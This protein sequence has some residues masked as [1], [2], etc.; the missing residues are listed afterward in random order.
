MA[1]VL[2]P[3]P[4]PSVVVQRRHTNRPTFTV[5]SACTL[6]LL[7]FL[8][9]IFAFA[10]SWHVRFETNLLP[11]LSITPWTLY[12]E[13]GWLT[14]IVLIITLL[15]R[16]LYL[17]KAGVSTLEYV[18]NL[19]GAVTL[20]FIIAIALTTMAL[21]F[22][23]PR[24]ATVI[25][26]GLT[27]GFVVAERL[28]VRVFL[29]GLHQRGIAQIR[30]LVI[31]S[32]ET[33]RA[34]LGRMQQTPKLGYHVVGLVDDD[35]RLWGRTLDGVAVLGAVEDL[36]RLLMRHRVDEVL[37]ADSGTNQQ[38]ILDLIARIP[39]DGID[40]KVAPSLFQLM[41]TGVSIDDLGGMPLVTVK[42]GA[43]RGWNRV[44]K[45]AMDVV[46]AA[47]VLVLFS[48][49][50]LVIAALVKLTSSGP[51]LYAQE[52]VGYNGERFQVLKY[53]SMRVDAEAGGPGWTTRDDDRRT[54]LGR[55]L[56][57][58][59]LDELPQFVNILVGDMSL[60]GPRPERP[61][62][63]EHFRRVIPRYME[64]HRERCGLTGWAQ[65]NGLRGDTSIEERTRYD[66]YYVDNWSL[67]LDL[68]IIAFT[69]L[70]VLR[71]DSAY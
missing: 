48:P 28:V 29:R 2:A 3:L 59:S 67:L 38:Q 37:I 8:A 14:A 4:E 34:M 11:I 32:G 1:Q 69:I 33:A 36:E 23:Y 57:R 52:R 16:N 18:W 49:L 21:K 65:V 70:R 31:G 19:A 43:L 45:R 44:V 55:L 60:V 40:V 12:A 61:V 20:G 71:D 51:A 22:D 62:Y 25:A 63:V 24:A 17:V 68:R 15:A 6:I 42:K 5:A 7:D 53:R 56:R 41:A 10:L 30:A 27:L 54:T 13:M 47:C 64:R 66:L 9:V 46:V 35:P 58:F 26:W 39:S 50:M